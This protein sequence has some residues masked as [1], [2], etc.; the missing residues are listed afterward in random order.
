MKDI[1]LTADPHF[2]HQ[3]I[4]EYADRPFSSV[5]EMNEVLIQNW[6]RVVKPQDDI[7]LL[8]D[9]AF[10]NTTNK[11]ELMGRLNGNVYL[12]RGNHDNRDTIPRLRRFGFAD[13]LTPDHYQPFYFAHQK[14]DFLMTH[15]PYTMQVSP[16]FYV[17][18]MRMPNVHGHVHNNIEGLDQRM[19]KC[20]SVEMT[21]YTP[22]HLDEIH[23]W[24]DKH[25]D[26]WTEQAELIELQA[27]GSS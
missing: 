19:F 5:E 12:V 26:F 13:V 27:G 17:P 3:R 15:V 22:L 1:W 9:W 2:F 14:G 18:P 11:Q 20:V 25:R 23:E 21:N 4:M 10:T 7:Y 24:M 8:G 16:A 6:N